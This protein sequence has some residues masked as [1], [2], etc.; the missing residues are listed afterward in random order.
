M[1]VNI[2]QIAIF[3]C[4]QWSYSSNEE[5][6]RVQLRNSRLWEVCKPTSRYQH[7]ICTLDGLICFMD[8]NN[9]TTCVYN[10]STRESTPWINTSFIQVGYLSQKLMKHVFGYDN[11]TKEYKVLA[12][13]NSSHS[14]VCEVLTVRRNSWRRIDGIPS[15]SPDDTVV[16]F[17]CVNGSIYLRANINLR[18]LVPLP[19][20]LSSLMF[21]VKSS[22]Q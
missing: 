7:L 2:I 17:V 5:G 9:G 16:S 11:G 14:L 13:W 18:M 22:E 4:F 6:G 21:V 12:L 1:F 3:V 19:K 10:S 20:L 8:K 15:I